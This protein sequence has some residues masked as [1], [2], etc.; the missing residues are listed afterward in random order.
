MPQPSTDV[1]FH[2]EQRFRQWWVWLLVLGVAALQWWGFVQQILLT[3]PWGDNPA[4]DWML[5]LFWALFGI[6]LPVFFLILRLTVE[7]TTEH[8]LIGYRPL[9]K[10]TVPLAEI[11][12]VEARTYRPIREYGGYGLRG[13]S[14]NAAFTVSGD[15]GVALTL[16]DGRRILIGSQRAAELALAIDSARQRKNK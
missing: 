14:R 8:V 3:R 5:W 9:T 2:E 12:E 1:L 13:T 10:R 15:Q 11:V 6:G 4:P 16:S 7:V